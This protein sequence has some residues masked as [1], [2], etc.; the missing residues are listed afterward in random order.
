MATSL[1][2]QLQRLAAPQTSV[3][4]ESRRTASILFDGKEAATK[5]REVIFDIGL[6]GLEELIQLNGAF[7]RFEETLFDRNAMD[8][9][10]SVED[11]TLNEM[12]D[13]NVRKFFCHLSPY[14]MLQPAHK[15]LEWLIRRF[16]VHQ[17][18][19]RDFVNFILPYH[20]TR[21]FVRC[22]QTLRFQPTNDQ[23]A[24]LE[25]IGKAG[26]P[27]SKRIIIEHFTAHPEFLKQYGKFLMEATTE[28]G[29]K[30][31]SLQAMFAFFCSTTLGVLESVES[32]TEN[33]VVAVLRPVAAGLASNAIDY[34]SACY[35]IVGQLVT[36]TAL[37]V[38]TLELLTKRL[39]CAEEGTQRSNAVMLLVL[40]FQ[41]QHERLS[42]IPNK[43]M[44]RLIRTNWIPQV[45]SE[46]KADGIDVLV[47]YRKILETSL[48]EICQSFHSI[49]F[50]SQICEQL[51]LEIALTDTEAEDIIQCVLDSYIGTGKSTAENNKPSPKPMDD[52]DDE[53]INLDSDSEEENFKSRHEKVTRWYSDFLKSLERQ[54]PTPFDTVV[55]RAM[56]GQEQYSHR[57]RNALKNVLGFLLQAS[58]DENEAFVFENLFHYDADRRSHA[59]N[60]I[61]EN[62][63]RLTSEGRGRLDLLRESISERLDDDSCAVVKEVLRLS[64]AQLL[65]TVGADALVTKLNHLTLKCAANPEYWKL[66]THRVIAMLT[67]EKIY[68]SVNINRVIIALYPLLFQ[69]G[70]DPVGQKNVELLLQTP[71]S[72]KFLVPAFYG[73]TANCDI[74]LRTLEE[75]GQC[76]NPVQVCF[77]I[78][79]LSSALPS[80]CS[81]DQADRVLRYARKQLTGH[82]FQ[83]AMSSDIQCLMA[84]KLPV[85]LITVPIRHIIERIRLDPTTV[86]MNFDRQNVALRLQL[87]IF[88][89]LLQRYC[90]IDPQFT[91]LRS[92]FGN[93][94]KTF[95]TQLYPEL[96]AR[97]EFLSHFYTVHLIE[98]PSDLPAEEDSSNFSIGLELQVRAIRLTNTMLGQ[99]VDQGCEI[100]FNALTNVILALTSECSLVRECV[101]STIKLIMQ[102]GAGNRLSK[103][104]GVFLRC[105]LKRREELSIDGEQLSMVLFIMREGE[106]GKTI[107]PIL[108]S[109]I[110]RLNDPNTPA[111]IA[112]GIVEMVKLLDDPLVLVRPATKVVAILEAVNGDKA[113]LTF[114]LYESK[115]LQILLGR[116]TADVTEQVMRNEICQRV[117]TVALQCH[118]AMVVP[119]RRKHCTP[120]ILMI[121]ALADELFEALP[122]SYAKRVLLHI[123]EAAAL[124]EHPETNSAT[125]KLFKGCTIDAALAVDLVAD[126]SNQSSQP[127]TVGSAKSLRNSI[128][129]VAPCERVLST[130]V[131]KRGVTLLEH[132]QNKK[133]L[134]NAHLLVP[135]LFECLKYCLDFEEQSVVEYVKQIILS[136]LLHC[137]VK[138]E[139]QV[140]LE[141]S[142]DVARVFGNVGTVFKVEQIVQCI[143]G[144]QNPQTH[145]HALLL[146]GHVARYVPEQVLHNM[147]E[148]FTFVGSSIVRQDDAYSFQII[149]K[150][151]ETIVPTIAGSES[152][153]QEQVIPILKIFSDIILDVP[154][155]RRIALYV[156]LLQTL[157][158]NEYLWVFLGVLIESDVMKGGHKAEQKSQRG[159]SRAEAELATSELSKRMEVALL[160]AREFEPTVI[161]QTCTNL[162]DYLRELPM[163]PEKRKKEEEEELMEVDMSDTVIFNV[164][165][166]TNRH[167]RH[168]K[169]ALVQFVGGLVSSVFVINKIAQLNKEETLGMKKYYQ[170]LIVGILTYVKDLSKTI[171]R[172]KAEKA[173]E[174]IPLYWRVM[175]T[176]CY[177]ILEGTI[178]LLSADTLIIVV[179]GLLKHRFLMVR[180][181]VLELLNNK[182]QYKQDYFEERHHPGLLQL[183]DP[184]M[185]LVKHLHEEESVVGTTIERS[186]IVQLCY[187]SL[188]H[189]SKILTQHATKKVQSVLADL[190]AE[191]HGYKKNPNPQVLASLI[192]CIGELCSNLG[193]HSINFLPKFVP[194]VNKFLNAQLRSEDPVDMLTYSI[195]LLMVKI[196]D[197]LSRFLSPYLCSMLVVLSQLYALV[198]QRNDSAMSA[199][200]LSRLALIWNNLAGTIA[201]RVMIPAIEES[202]HELVGEGE[203]SAVGPLMKLLSTTFGKLKSSDFTAIRGEL[204]EL[205]LTVLQFRC[206][207]SASDMFT[208]AAIDA[209]EAHVIRAFVVL[210]L[211]LSEST[212]RPLFYQV[213]E[214]SIRESSSNDRAITF[215]NVCAHVA[216]ALKSLFVLFASDLVTIA[217]KLLNATNSAKVGDGGEGHEEELHFALESKNVTLLRY[218]LKTLYCIVLYDNQNFINAVRFDMLLGPITDQLE[219]GLIMNVTEVRTL[220][221]DC[222]AQMAVAVMDDSLWRQLN[223]Q[224]LLKTRNNEPEVRM[225]ALE[226]CTEIARKLGESYAPLLPETIPFLAELMEDDNEDVEKAVHHSCR[227]IGR[228]TG[229]DLQKYF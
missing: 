193:P 60:Y 84:G 37:S 96:G 70:D 68:T 73:S 136:L 149:S 157:G 179:H 142:T 32:V 123:V 44:K 132:L 122:K 107:K 140:A 34:A 116:Y 127:T 10:R 108:E 53:T 139:Q 43:L 159:K 218:V 203:L 59:V 90:I 66:V 214:W 19:R 195:V 85:D 98:R 48:G 106:K 225:F 198:E 120:A 97:V 178:S 114:D 143:R 102:L 79:L 30:A 181:K 182:L 92:I 25:P 21:M 110:E 163:E 146:L 29:S 166:H 13:A 211:K 82:R 187:I 65:A 100:T 220:V 180:R 208:L 39:C 209:T 133:K 8:L 87:S 206:N 151:I 17:F 130:A 20:E 72:K 113:R 104:T 184:L 217:A 162:I 42:P 172:L 55:K 223:Y 148:I 171:D 58:C 4:V 174:K 156:K 26:V 54:Y 170:N 199:N 91:D 210:I 215:F 94:L 23:L 22:I 18:N 124:S 16:N 126:M 93:L 191:L 2:A 119:G 185:E 222:L 183:L 9:Q 24:F 115:M 227:E 105:L 50:Y 33:Y 69:L 101:M 28:L 190:V 27:P 62:F 224:V 196:V 176:Y 7:A 165:A 89:D 1:A 201:P 61:V 77:N 121:E 78:L 63:E 175:L 134:E 204:A 74:L 202:Y 228:A 99:M 135:K 131:W 76:T 155:H 212:F 12:L 192:L 213:F 177:D 137:I 161:V 46:V 75:T 216:E 197:T 5:D 189:L 138:V 118:K 205:F 141:G 168:F 95:L 57:K 103:P 145:H 6:S 117:I 31:N 160:I 186:V 219:N 226:A 188:R 36:K 11:Q 194:M 15:C 169:Y 147:M 83:Y 38:D 80:S 14:F 153:S 41:T 3:Q 64:P 112:A 51:L 173:D 128:I 221:I 109:F 56:K 52:D 152:S 47:C 164:K 158:A 88:S 129:A 111:Y 40:I 71:F 49:G 154:E 45:L 125:A 67:N 86:D 81:V 229:E 167:L 200:M 35:M 207:Q 150:T 144:S